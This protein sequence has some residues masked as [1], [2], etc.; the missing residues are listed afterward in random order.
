M[1]NSTDADVKNTKYLFNTM[2]IGKETNQLIKR[3]MHTLNR[4]LENP[5]GWP[6][7]DFSVDTKAGKA[8]LVS[9]VGR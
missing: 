3:A 4:P 8:P 7:L 2:I 9:L 1:R 5:K 6:G